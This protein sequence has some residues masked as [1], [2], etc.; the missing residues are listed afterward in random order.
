MAFS[1]CHLMPG[2]HYHPTRV[3][4][5]CIPFYNEDIRRAI[6]FKK[7]QK[8]T[9]KEGK[10]VLVHQKNAEGLKKPMRPDWRGQSNWEFV[11]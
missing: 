6:P 8:N 3:A 4:F 9:K 2:Q 7:V 1:E 10:S 5:H 11:N